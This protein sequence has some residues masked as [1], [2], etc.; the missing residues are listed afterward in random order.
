MGT[1]YFLVN[2][3]VQLLYLKSQK[4][5][6]LDSFKLSNI[7]YS[8]IVRLIQ[9]SQTL[10][11]SLQDN[12][13]T[14]KHIMQTHQQSSPLNP[15]PFQTTSSG[16][17][18]LLAYLSIVVLLPDAKIPPLTANLYPFVCLVNSYSFSE[19]HLKQFPFLQVSLTALEQNEYLLLL[20]SSN[21]I[22]FYYTVTVHISALLARV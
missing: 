14:P 11:V 10:N 7:L 17:A 6:W 3:S 19:A 12:V 22:L 8:N 1:L 5:N 18:M 21:H 13:E 9:G 20:L 2:F 15:A 16:A 4:S